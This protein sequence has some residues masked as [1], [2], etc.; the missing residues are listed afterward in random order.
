MSYVSSMPQ[1]PISHP[2]HTRLG[3]ASSIL[4][5]V[6]AL[7]VI[8]LF[9]ANPG[10]GIGLLIAEIAAWATLVAAGVG[11]ILGIIGAFQQDC[12]RLFG[13]VGIGLNIAAV[14]VA[15]TLMAIGAIAY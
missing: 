6:I 12:Q 1:L 11:L 8:A 13:F 15:G 10:E 9:V 5:G 3:I 7:G 14:F 4:S 2:P